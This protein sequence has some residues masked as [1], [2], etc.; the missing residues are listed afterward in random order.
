MDKDQ[1][2]TRLLKEQICA[3]KKENRW[4][5]FKS[6]YQEATKLGR[7]ISALSN[8]ACLDREEFAYLYFGVD[9]DTLG[10]KGT[11]FD[12][13]AT[14]AQGNQSLEIYLRQYVSPKIDFKIED[15]MYEGAVRVVRFKIPAAVNEPTAFMGK[16]YVRVDSH[17]TELP[18]IPTGCVIFTLQG[19]IGLR[20]LLRMPLWMTLTQ[21]LYDWLVKDIN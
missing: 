20:R 21:T 1:K 15:F 6:N 13:A 3:F 16:P 18:H 5:E 10:I 14:K 12:S 2:Y 8:G 11:T 19:L 9:N 4:L 17:V 7:Y